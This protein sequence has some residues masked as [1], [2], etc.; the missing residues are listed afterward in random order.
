[1]AI[2]SND[3]QTAMILNHLQKGATINP[4]EALDKY[5]CFRLGAVI[6]NLKKEGYEISSTLYYFTK[7]SGKQGHYAVYRLESA[8]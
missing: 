1:M 5:G 7:P 3:S 8:K 4:I 6:Y 2:H